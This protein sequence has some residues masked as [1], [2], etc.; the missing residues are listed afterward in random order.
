MKSFVRC[1]ALGAIIASLM[2]VSAQA[3]LGGDAEESTDTTF[4]EGKKAVQEQN[5]KKAVDRLEKFVTAN[6]GD[7]DAR[8]YLGYSY[9]KLGFMEH[10]FLHYNEALK[11]NPKHKHAH[12]YIG[13]AYLMVDKVKEAEQ[14][15]AEL[16]KL[17]SPIPCEEQKQLKQAIDDYK[18]KK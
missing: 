5:W 10:A 2:T 18:K 13:E 7:A 17:C 4:Q 6:P 3:N 9:R 11:I 8:N 14:H 15:L 1:I 12:E 16:S